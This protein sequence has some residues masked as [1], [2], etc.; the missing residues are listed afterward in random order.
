MCATQRRVCLQALITT[1]LYPL[2]AFVEANESLINFVATMEEESEA[3]W[4]QSAT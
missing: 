3:S 1:A 4:L 2:T